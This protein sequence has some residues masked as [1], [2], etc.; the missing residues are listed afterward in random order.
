MSNIALEGT[1]EMHI[2]R[3]WWQTRLK[4]L[5][6]YT[7]CVL[8]H[9]YLPEFVILEIDFNDL[10]SEKPEVVGSSMENPVGR[11]LEHYPVHVVVLSHVTS[12]ACHKKPFYSTPK[13]NEIAPM[14]DQHT[15]VV[16]RA[17]RGLTNPLVLPFLAEGAHFNP[18]G[19]IYIYIDR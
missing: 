5:K 10:S 7:T 3:C 1:A 4:E 9:I 6:M 17:H 13:F 14:L 16:C 18:M 2:T 19:Y 8:F 12:R 15:C 11:L